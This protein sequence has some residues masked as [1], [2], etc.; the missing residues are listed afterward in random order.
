[1]IKFCLLKICENT[2]CDNVENSSDNNCESQ[3]EVSDVDCSH[4]NQNLNENHDIEQSSESDPFVRMSI[5]IK[6]SPEYLKDY[7]CNIN[8]SSTSSRLY[9]VLSKLAENGL[10]NSHHFAFYGIYS[11]CE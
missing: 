4:I 8:V 1:M 3:I 11:I 7:H 2:P 10:P 5:R 9:M 6:R